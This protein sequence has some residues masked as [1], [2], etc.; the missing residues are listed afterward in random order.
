M[1]RGRRG[2]EPH[3]QTVVR[4]TRY[5]SAATLAPRARRAHEVS[6]RRRDGRFDEQELG[7]ATGRNGLNAGSITNPIVVWLMVCA[8]TA[9]PPRKA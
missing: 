8:P 4:G 5:S 7:D 6:C 3:L 9:L 2:R 1:A